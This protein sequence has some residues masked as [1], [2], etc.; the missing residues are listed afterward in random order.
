MTSSLAVHDRVPSNCMILLCAPVRA[1]VALT[2]VIQWMG[3][4]R[5]VALGLANDPTV[6]IFSGGGNDVDGVWSVSE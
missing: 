1:A 4:R 3:L 6:A 2:T 5:A